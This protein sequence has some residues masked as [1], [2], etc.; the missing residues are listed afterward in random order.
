MPIKCIDKRITDTDCMWIFIRHGGG[1]EGKEEE[2][3][4]THDAVRRGEVG[5]T[6]LHKK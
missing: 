3:E 6:K 2:E 5:F 1:G 4:E